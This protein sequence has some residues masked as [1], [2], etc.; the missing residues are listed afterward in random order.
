MEHLSELEAGSIK[1]AL[2]A[3]LLVSSD[4]VSASQL[5]GILGSTPGESASLLA[6]LKVE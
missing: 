1:G 4:P 5:S 2:E 6:D 3:L